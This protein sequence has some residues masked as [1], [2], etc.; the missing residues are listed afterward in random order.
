[1]PELPDVTVYCEAIA[2][3]FGGRTLVGTRSASPFVVRTVAPSPKDLVGATL[4]GTRRI[5]KRIAL[6]FSGDRFVVVHL[7]IS[8]RFKLG[9]RG[10]KIP[11]KLGVFAFDFDDGTLLLTEASTKKRASIHV[12][13]GEATLASHDPGGVEL[14]APDAVVEA[15]L[16][17]DRH[18]LKRALTDPR[19][20]SGVGNA[21][22]DEALWEAGLSPL[23]WTDR[24]PPEARARLLAAL[25]SVVARFTE[26]VRREALAAPDGFPPKVTAFRDDMAVHGRFGKPCP[27]CGTEV[28]RIAYAD[29]E[30][31]YCPRC[32]TDGKLL[33]DR[34]R[35]RLLGKDW[36][37]TLEELE[38]HMETRRVG[39]GT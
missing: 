25:R 18:T 14:D 22:S 11:G 3:R 37:K 26:A 4:V 7:M 28:Q 8:G 5:G 6:A 1:M 30:T 10:V 20:L 9:A 17:R 23:T 15:R 19:I 21:Y 38:A 16:F 13:A 29:N 33:A 31:N 2:R 36:P 24:V 27:R 34:G 12:V 32:Q 35:S 39:P